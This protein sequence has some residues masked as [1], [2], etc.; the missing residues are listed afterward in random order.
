MRRETA[1]I[2]A[3]CWIDLFTSDPDRSQAFYCELFGWTAEPPAEEYGG[4]F[5]FDLDGVRVAGS[6]RNDGSSGAP[7]LWS[8]YLA[9]R[10]AE[11]TIGAATA[12]RQPG[13]RPGDAGRDLGTIGVVTDPGGAGIG[14]WQ[15][16]E[17]KGF[18]IIGEPGAP[19]WFELHTRE[20]DKSVQFYNDVFAW[21]AHTVAESPEFRYTTLRRGRDR[22]SRGS[23]MRAV[24]F[25]KAFRRTG[26]CTSAWR[27]PTRRSRRFPTS[28]V[29]SCS[30]PRT[31]RTVGWPRR[32][33]RPA[34]CSSSA[35]RRS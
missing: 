8:V 20:Y 27:T 25:P 12:A 1:P 2:G 10:D 28:A 19:S 21:D 35:R 5:N 23:W 24:S 29:R 26:P 11:A 14:M 32:A 30:R 15:P 13:D 7:D 9:V 6:M 16:A 22:S 34:R 4:Y 31:R 33:T 3:P 17:H 18:G